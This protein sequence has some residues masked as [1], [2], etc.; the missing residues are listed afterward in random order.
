MALQTQHNSQIAA[1]NLK[2]TQAQRKEWGA[3]F[4]AMETGFQGVLAKFAN[5][6]AT[7][8]QTIRGLFQSVAQAVASTLEQ[9]AAKNIATMLEQAATGKTIK[10]KELAGDASAAAGGAYKAV[11]GIPYVG[12]FLAPA[13]AATAYAGVL[14]F[15]SGIS[16]AG[17]YDI[18]ASVNP[19]VQ[20]HAREMIL[21]ASIADPLRGMLANGG[22]GGGHTFHI[23]ATDANS[24]SRQLAQQGSVLHQTLKKHLKGTGS[25]VPTYT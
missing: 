4:R 1:L 9:M 24:F 6:T 12:P 14:A 22:G 23:H 13:A 19:V 11:V 3:T 7:L 15:G 8:G 21:P 10:L 18:P 16:A 2:A 20:T 5:R 17:G 25:L